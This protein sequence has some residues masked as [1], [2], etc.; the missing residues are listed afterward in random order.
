MGL[1][2]V[3]LLGEETHHAGAF[4][5]GLRPSQVMMQQGAPWILGF[6]LDLILFLLTRCVLRK[7]APKHKRPSMMNPADWPHSEGLQEELGVRGSEHRPPNGPFTAPAT[8]QQ[9]LLPAVSRRSW[10]VN[11]WL[12][13]SHLLLSPSLK[14]FLKDE[15]TSG[16]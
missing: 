5:K 9:L 10:K 4:G 1:C 11:P 12:S 7:M 14:S 6:S 8:V 13:C 16:P 3:G 2:P 15:E